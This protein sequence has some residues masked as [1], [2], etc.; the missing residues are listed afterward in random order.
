MKP[1]STSLA[2]LV[3]AGC[4]TTGQLPAAPSSTVSIADI[5]IRMAQHGFGA[6]AQFASCVLPLCPQV[7][8]KLP[9]PPVPA[10]RDGEMSSFPLDPDPIP[11]PRLDAPA[12]DNEQAPILPVLRTSPQRSRRS[13]AYARLHALPRPDTFPRRRTN[14]PFSVLTAPAARIDESSVPPA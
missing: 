13:A 9:P 14:R 8:P 10:A 7:T 3:L 1:I 2:C 11:A 4:A 5:Q 12:R 6:Q